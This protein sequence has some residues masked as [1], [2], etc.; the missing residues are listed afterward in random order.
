[1]SDINPIPADTIEA[2]DCM[3]GVSGIK[4]KCILKLDNRKKLANF[5]NIA[6][7]NGFDHF[8][9]ICFPDYH[10]KEI[11]KEL[12]D[13]TKCIGCGEKF[14]YDNMETDD[15]GERYC[16]PCWDEFSPIFQEEHRKA[17]EEQEREWAE[18][19]QDDRL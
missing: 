15:A 19:E 2:L 5:V 6:R 17:V 1:M 11:I 10:S 14:P 12:L 16:Q 3:N 8:V 4:L 9:S 7:Q 13:F 18:K